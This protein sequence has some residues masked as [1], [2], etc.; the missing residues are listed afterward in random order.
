MLWF[1]RNVAEKFAPSIEFENSVGESVCKS[2]FY[3]NI[4]A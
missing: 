2:R 1:G 4:I 3:W